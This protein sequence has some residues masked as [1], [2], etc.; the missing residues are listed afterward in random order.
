M[1]KKHEEYREYFKCIRF[2]DRVKHNSLGPN[3]R[4][5]PNNIGFDGRARLNGFGSGYLARPN[6]VQSDWGYN[7]IHEI[8]RSH[9]NDPFY[10]TG[11]DNK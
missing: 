11:G 1:L 5:R 7:E 4:S 6:N 3:C 10:L 8:L 9:R 2:S